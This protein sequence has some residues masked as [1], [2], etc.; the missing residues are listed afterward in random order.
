MHGSGV[1]GW[2]LASGFFFGR[3]SK[4]SSRHVILAGISIRWRRQGG[5]EAEER[6][7]TLLIRDIANGFHTWVESLPSLARSSSEILV[8]EAAGPVAKRAPVAGRRACTGTDRETTA[9]MGARAETNALDALRI[10]SWRASRCAVPLPDLAIMVYSREQ[11]SRS[12]LDDVLRSTLFWSDGQLLSE[13][14]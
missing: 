7:G 2:G 3:G 13:P 6:A 12:C 4:A 1:G 10:A 14:V 9:A 5:K 11:T 8:G